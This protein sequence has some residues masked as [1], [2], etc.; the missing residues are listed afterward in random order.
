MK[1]MF[2]WHT[3]A[4][5]Y[6]QKKDF[7][8][9][10]KCF[11]NAL[12]LEPDNLQIMRDTACLQI[13]VRDHT[14]HTSTRLSI[15]KLKPNMIQNWLAF[16]VAHHLVHLSKLREEISLPFS[17]LCILWTT[18]LKLL[19]WNLLSWLITMFTGL[20]PSKTQLISLGCTINSRKIKFKSKM[21]FCTI[22]YFTKLPKNLEKLLK[23]LNLLSSSWKSS[24]RT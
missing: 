21:N 6:K 17:K 24:H 4:S 7:Y 20:L 18:L 2:C 11:Q 16:T 9:A 23:L 3:C 8:E 19:I 5:I 14:N 13:Q 22:N 1:S 12:R 15:L 10:A